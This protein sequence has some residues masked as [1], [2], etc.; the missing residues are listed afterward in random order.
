MFG[1]FHMLKTLFLRH[2]LYI[3]NKAKGIHQ[4]ENNQ[5]LQILECHI[6]M[7]HVLM[8][9]PIGGPGLKYSFLPLV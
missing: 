8:V 1:A 7:I 6:Q 9:I 2:Q 4:A 3:A 5:I